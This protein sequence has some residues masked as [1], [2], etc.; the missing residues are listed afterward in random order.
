MKPI[1]RGYK[2]WCLADDYGYAYKFEVYAGKK[3]PSK[4]SIRAS[5][6]VWQHCP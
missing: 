4:Y 5:R 2:I 3:C 6:N 1:K